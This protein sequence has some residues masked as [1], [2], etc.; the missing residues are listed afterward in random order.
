MAAVALPASAMR[1][2]LIHRGNPMTHD[3]TDFKVLFNSRGRMP[4]YYYQREALQQMNIYQHASRV[5]FFSPRQQG[6]TYFLQIGNVHHEKFEKY[7]LAMLK[8]KDQEL[9]QTL[10]NFEDA[11]SWRGI[12]P[13]QKRA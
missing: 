7:I 3:S 4:L 5:A 2:V 1:D 6:K 9:L 13:K 12:L 11:E 8:K 10:S